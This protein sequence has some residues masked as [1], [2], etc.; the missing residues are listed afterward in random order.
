[1]IRLPRPAPAAPGRLES[2]GHDTIP[3]EE[4]EP[5]LGPDRAEGVLVADVVTF[6]IALALFTIH[7]STSI[8][9]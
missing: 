4:R 6:E 7:S 8:E 2:E 3:D 1:M 5:A 9:K